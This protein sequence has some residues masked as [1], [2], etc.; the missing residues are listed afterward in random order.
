M[1]SKERPA[2]ALS[3]EETRKRCTGFQS[4]FF[5]DRALIIAAN[6]GPVTFDTDEDGELR[7][8]RGGGGLVTALLGMCRHANATWISCAR[9]EADVEWRSGDVQ[10]GDEGGVIHLKF[11]TLDASVYND[12]YNVIANPLLWFLQHSMWDVV[13]SPVI[14]RQTWKAWEEGYLAVNERFAEA[15]AEEARSSDRPTLV[16]LQD[17][18]LY[19]T[20]RFLREWFDP[21]LA[22]PAGL[23][24]RAGEC[25][26]LL[27]FVHIPWPGPEYWRILPRE[28]RRAIVN[29]LCAVDVLGFQTELDAL[30]F[31]RT[32][33]SYLPRAQVEYE[34]RRIW[35]ENHATHVRDFPISI[36]VEALKELATADE[37]SEYRSEI[38]EVVGD[39]KLILRVDRIEPSKNIVRGFWAF[40]EMLELYPELHDEVKFLALLVPSRMG[41]GQYQDYLDELMA[42]AGQVNAKHGDSDWE[43]I[44]ILVGD[45]YPRAVAAMQLYD[46]LLVNSIADGMNLVAKEGPTVNERDGVLV[47]SERIGARQQLETGAIVISPCDIY[48]TAEA[49]H[50]SL[51]MEFEERKVWAERLRWLIEREDITAW[52][53]HQLET[54][55]GLN[56]CG[57]Q[58]R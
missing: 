33:E 20:A 39:R 14:D 35:Y 27:H 57:A 26:T 34:R 58:E 30:N 17:Y 40:D 32:C 21:G 8:E 55:Q 54:V 48:A 19:L 22:G 46:V 45:N 42:A 36:D 24:A 44:R 3:V 4:E 53:C 37:V 15:I 25:P 29:G 23:A 41:V 38:Q 43:P 9:T 51:K 12:Y 18:H 47:L 11:L 52:L 5:A 1:T 2:R 31:L 13:T 28:M 7:H 56:L 6:R 49:L 10:L 16:M 50:Q